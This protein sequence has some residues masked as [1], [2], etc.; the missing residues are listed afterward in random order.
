[1]CQTS[2]WTSNGLPVPP[3]RFI[4]HSYTRPLRR[5]SSCV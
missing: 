4:V 2:I 1:M 3:R 5:L